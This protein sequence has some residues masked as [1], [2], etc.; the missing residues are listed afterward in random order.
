MLIITCAFGLP[1][2]INKALTLFLDETTAYITLTVLGLLGFIT[3]RYWIQ[4]IYVRLMKRKYQNMEGFRN[5]R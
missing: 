3:H 5:T 4:N 2:L 1:L